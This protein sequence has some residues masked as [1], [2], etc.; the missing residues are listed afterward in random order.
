MGQRELRGGAGWTAQAPGSVVQGIPRPRDDRVFAP[1][2]PQA[3]CTGGGRV[4]RRPPEARMGSCAR[5]RT[6]AGRP[7]REARKAEGGGRS[8]ERGA[9][10]ARA[11]SA[12]ARPAPG[13][14]ARWRGPRAVGGERQSAMGRGWGLLVGLLGVVWL[15]RSG[16]G[17]EQQQ[18]TAAQRCFCQVRRAGCAS[19]GA[20]DPAARPAPRSRSPRAGTPFDGRGRLGSLSHCFLASC[21]GCSAFTDPGFWVDP[22]PGLL[23]RA[24]PGTSPAFLLSTDSWGD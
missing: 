14:Q 19:P 23:A 22:A 12:G 20:G 5:R 7:E 8:A 4:G 2:E 17:E 6:S 15:L 24:L 1:G 11:S 18:E 3:R 13:S 9:G 10:P 21:H 16:Q